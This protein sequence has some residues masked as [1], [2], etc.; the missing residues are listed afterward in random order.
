M[1]ADK[2]KIHALAASGRISLA[3]KD[4]VTAVEHL[5]RASDSLSE[6]AGILCDLGIAYAAQGEYAAGHRQ[7]TKIMKLIASRQGHRA[8]KAAFH[9]LEGHLCQP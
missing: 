2:D 4:Y 1:S 5:S 6:D 8:A 9:R 3:Q 7:L